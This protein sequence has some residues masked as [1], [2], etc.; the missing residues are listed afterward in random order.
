MRLY[1]AGSRGTIPMTAPDRAAYGG[2]TTCLLVTGAQ[3]ERVIV[4]CGSGLPALADRLGPGPDL[5]VLLTHFHLDHLLGLP[6]FGPLYDPQARLHLVAALGEGASCRDALAGL[7][8]SPYWPL[9]L[10]DLPA[11]LEFT[12]LP[13]AMAG[14]PLRRGGLEIRW[15]ALPHPG[16]CA[17]YRIDEPATASSLVMATDAEWDEAPDDLLA[18]FI[19]L[20][21]RPT[22]CDLL[23]CDG[24]YDSRTIR[25]R[26]GWGH[27]SWA[28]AA[29]LARETGAAHLLLTHHDPQDD[30]Q[31]LARREQELQADLPRAELARQG[32]TIELGRGKQA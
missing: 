1:I 25:R 13:R 15:A 14:E 5:L 2:D 19:D 16:G 10:A 7:I 31:A 26:R 28:R 12:D 18:A 8:G 9:P 27:T 20:C 30:D 24:Q 32:Q 6:S 4:D 21:R 22:P 11:S 23:I 29:E 3:G 17:A